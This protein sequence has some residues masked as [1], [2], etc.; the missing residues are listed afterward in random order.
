MDKLSN[1]SSAKKKLLKH[2]VYSLRKELKLALETEKKCSDRTY[3]CH[4]ERNIIQNIL[5]EK[6]E[7]FAQRAIVGNIKSF[8]A[9]IGGKKQQITQF[10]CKYGLDMTIDNLN[11]F[12]DFCAIH[13]FIPMIDKIL[14]DG[15]DISQLKEVFSLFEFALFENNP[16]IANILANEINKLEFA[17]QGPAREI[18]SYIQQISTYTTSTYQ[19]LLGDKLQKTKNEGTLSENIFAEVALRIENQI[20]EK[21]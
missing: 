8:S 12:L 1:P 3:A 11:S 10:D 16:L 19:Y 13:G 2:Q 9:K 17:F 4:S 20:R 18:L 7:F 5:Q 6:A 21:V 15:K 14:I